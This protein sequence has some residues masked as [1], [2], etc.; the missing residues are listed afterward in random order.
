MISRNELANAITEYSQTLTSK[1]IA[2][3]GGTSAISHTPAGDWIRN[4]VEWWQG[5]PWMETLSYVAIMLLIIE[6]AFIVWAWY[7]KHKRGE[8]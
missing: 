3:A 6:R 4:A 1:F 5:W 2:V 8:I 7:R